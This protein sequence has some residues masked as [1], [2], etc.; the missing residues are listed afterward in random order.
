[1][2]EDSPKEPD[3]RQSDGDG[4]PPE[5]KP[6]AENAPSAAAPSSETAGGAVPADQSDAKPRVQAV[7]APPKSPADRRREVSG[8]LVLGFTAIAT[9]A[10]VYMAFGKMWAAIF[11]VG[12][13]ASLV[14][15]FIAKPWKSWV[16]LWIAVLT[17]VIIGVVVFIFNRFQSPEPPSHQ[18]P[19]SCQSRYRG[20]IVRIP[21]SN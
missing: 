11:G 2:A 9:L 19:R 1:M 17:V 5:N 12:L 3:D 14:I 20:D 10:E 15:L 18:H 8:G 6:S 16:T 7:E 4:K 13:I 21:M